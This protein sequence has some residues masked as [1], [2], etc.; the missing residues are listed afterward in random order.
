VSRHDYVVVG[1]GSTG[2]WPTNPGLWDSD[3]DWDFETVPQSALDDRS[4][5][6]QGRTLGASSSISAQP[7][8]RRHSADYDGRA[9]VGNDGWDNHVAAE[10]F[11]RIEGDPGEEVVLSVEATNSLQ[12]LVLSAALGL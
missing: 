7:Y 9:A 6:V 5:V 3:T 11:E 8:C 10:R 2:C 4:L 12:L 1:A